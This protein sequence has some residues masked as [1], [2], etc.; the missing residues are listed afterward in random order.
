MLSLVIILMFLTLISNTTSSEQLSEITNANQIESLNDTQ[1]VYTGM[2]RIYIVE[3][4]SRWNMYD[5]NPYHNGFL[6]F[7]YEDTLSLEYLKPVENTITWSGN[8]SKD[9]V[10]VIASIFN[11]NTN[12]GYAF[13]PSS[14]PFDAYFVD[15]SAKAYPD[16]T[17][18]N[19]RTNSITHSVFIEEGTATWCKN[20][21]SM[22]SALYNVSEDSSFPFYY[23]AMIEDVND[24]ANTRVRDQL[25][26]YGFPTIYLDGGKQAMIG[27]NPDESEIESLI[28]QCATS[29][30]HD[31][32]LNISVD[33]IG[34]GELLINYNVTSLEEVTEQSITIN[35]IF[36][37][38][39]KVRAIIE[40][41]GES[42]L[43]DVDW[44]ITVKGGLLDRIDH[45]SEGTIKNFPAGR[46][47]YIRTNY[48][49]FQL[50]GYGRIEIV[51]QVGSTVKTESGI[52][53]GKYLFVT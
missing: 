40:N 37:G 51:V 24:K 26:I 35:R 28:E 7:A 49:P 16:Q 45:N 30:V 12:V 21:P 19:M 52:L 36:G 23:V 47:K 6:D 27:G 2:L 53:L 18:S 46:K 8:V 38:R 14:K 31:I 9:N 15:A 25:N 44:K 10:F 3:T 39:K 43:S 17:G 5:G 29:D 1:S 13:P 48:R 34:D 41:I 11:P 33:W 50:R 42:D 4:T 32:S 20:C 22:A